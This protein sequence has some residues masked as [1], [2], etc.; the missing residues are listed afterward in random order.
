VI[1]AFLAACVPKP[2][3]Y[4]LELPGTDV[5]ETGNLRV[6]FSPPAFKATLY[7]D[8]APVAELDEAGGVERILIRGVAPGARN[9]EVRSFN[10]QAE[11]VKTAVVA[12]GEVTDVVLRGPEAQSKSQRNAAL[13]VSGIVLV[14]GFV[15]LFIVLANS[16]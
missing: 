8:Q 10:H 11:D 1:A 9:V 6:S 4:R 15:L 2:T 14:A 16:T 12:S 3:T 5:G 13:V 7:I